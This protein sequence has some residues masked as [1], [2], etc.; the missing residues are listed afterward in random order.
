[1]E[2]LKIAAYPT[3]VVLDIFPDALYE[4]GK[5][6]GT[7]NDVFLRAF[8]SVWDRRRPVTPPEEPP[9]S[10]PF[11]PFRVE[12]ALPPTKGSPSP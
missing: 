9:G 11:H 10:W 12:S 8:R 4:R 5:I 3:V 2:Q 7:A 6:E 1:M